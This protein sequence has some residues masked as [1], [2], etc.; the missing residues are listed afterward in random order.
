[1]RPVRE[2][3]DNFRDAAVFVFESAGDSRGGVLVVEREILSPLRG[4]ETP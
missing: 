4:A 1:M 2:V 3:S